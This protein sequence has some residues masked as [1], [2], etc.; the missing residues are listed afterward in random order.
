MHFLEP[1]IPLVWQLCSLCG[2]P[3]LQY[4]GKLSLVFVVVLFNREGYLLTF[5]SNVGLPNGV[6]PARGSSQLSKNST[7]PELVV[8]EG[9]TFRPGQAVRI[10]FQLSETAGEEGQ[11]AKLISGFLSK[12]AAGRHVINEEAE[13]VQV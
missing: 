8:V 1:N 11:F 9:L 12:A 13:K 6:H 4:K 10:E 7:E 5:A 2:S 3:Q